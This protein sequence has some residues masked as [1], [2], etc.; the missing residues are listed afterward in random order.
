[1]GFVRIELA[2]EG[3][4][5]G[6]DSAVYGLGLKAFIRGADGGFGAEG[7]GGFGAD[8]LNVSKSDIYDDSRS[9]PVSTPPPV[10]LN[11]GIPTP[12]NIPPNCGAV[13]A[14]LRS[15]PPVVSLLLLALV[16]SPAPAPGIGGARPLGSFPRLETAGTPPFRGP[17][18]TPDVFPPTMGA[19]RSFV[20]VFF[21]LAPLE[22]S[23]RSAPY[24][25][26][27]S[28]TFVMKE[29]AASLGDGHP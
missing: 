10:F 14:P 15:T 5:G 19:D 6:E 1:M 28:S 23:V 13:F 12:A 9:A 25:E 16:G 29:S 7:V 27:Q 2:A 18:E 3:G 17:A 22:I 20:T 21:N 26:C 4:C 24:N 11:F 8:G